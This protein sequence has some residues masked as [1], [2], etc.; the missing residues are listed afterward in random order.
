MSAESGANALEAILGIID[1]NDLPDA[2]SSARF[3]VI[4]TLVQALEASNAFAKLFIGE[5]HLS[6]RAQVIPSSIYLHAFG[7]FAGSFLESS[8]FSSATCMPQSGFAGRGF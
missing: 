4:S 8:R 5:D 1:C 7:L 2:A 3:A 6:A